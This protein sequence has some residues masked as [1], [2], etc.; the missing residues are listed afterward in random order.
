MPFENVF[1]VSTQLAPASQAEIDDLQRQLGVDLPSGYAP[2][3]T[4]FG[5]GDYCDYLAIYDPKYLLKQ[6][7]EIQRMWSLHWYFGEPDED[8]PRSLTQ[9]Q[10]AQSIVIGHTIDGDYLMFYPPRADRLYIL[11]RHE[12]QVYSVNADF[13][14]LFGWNS[15]LENLEDFPTF[16]PYNNQ[17]T[18]EVTTE[19]ADFDLQELANKFIEHWSDSPMHRISELDRSYIILYLQAIGAR[20]QLKKHVRDDSGEGVIWFHISHNRDASETL[21]AFLL[22]LGDARLA[23]TIPVQRAKKRDNAGNP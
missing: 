6:Y 14:D 4:R 5:A 3:I 12:S 13:S 11:P 23:Q 9:Q 18:L 7:K 17:T 16:H 20:V 22:S 8:N 15:A 21:D 10:A 1:L 19:R 2:F